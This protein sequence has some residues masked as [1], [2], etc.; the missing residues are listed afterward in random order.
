[1]D[2]SLRRV[3]KFFFGNLVERLANQNGCCYVST[4]EILRSDYW[5]IAV[6]DDVTARYG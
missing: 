2:C 4:N 6:D 5:S 1:M 3:G